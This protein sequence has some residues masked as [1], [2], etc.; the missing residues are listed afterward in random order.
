ML[1]KCSWIFSGCLLFAFCFNS[2]A[3]GFAPE[4]PAVVDSAGSENTEKNSDRKSR[5]DFSETEL[6]SIL[7]FADEH[8]PE[9]GRLLQH[10]RKSRPNELQRAA[11]ELNQQI[12]VLQKLR[13][14]NPTRYAHHLELWKNDSQIRVLV[15]KWSRTKDESLELEIRELLRQRRDA[16]LAQLM[17]DQLRL[18]GQL[19]KVEKQIASFEE[20]SDS[21]IEREWEQLAKKTNAHL[22]KQQQ[23]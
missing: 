14:K 8:H 20:S 10:L 11:R 13:D 7:A 9:L 15:A 3:F 18:K 16:K 19:Q 6:E 22:K 4:P 1:R 2:D 17:A 23:K 5:P 12:Q 21:E